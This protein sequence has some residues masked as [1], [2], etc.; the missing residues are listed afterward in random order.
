M[1]FPFKV[2]LPVVVKLAPSTVPMV[3]L[4]LVDVKDIAPPLPVLPPLAEAFNVPV[5]MSPLA[6]KVIGPTISPTVVDEVFIFP[7]LI[8]PD[9]D[10]GVEDAKVVPPSETGKIEGGETEDRP[11]FK[12]RAE[13]VVNIA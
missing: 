6:D 5:V 3:R 13:L 2:V 9:D 1:T 4:P 11:A 12:I 10:A 8:L 7:T